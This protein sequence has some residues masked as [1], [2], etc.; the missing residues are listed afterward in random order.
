MGRGP[1][2]NDASAI[3]SYGPLVKVH[4]VDG[5]FELFRAYFAWPSS[6]GA[7][8]REVGAAKG[9]LSMLRRLVA[10]PGVTHVACAFDHVIESFRNQMFAGYKTGEGMDP[11]LYGQ[12]GLAEQVCSALGIVTWSM[13]EFEADDA[14]ATGAARYAA[15]PEVEQVLICSPDKDLMQCVS[16]ERVVCWDR[17]RDRVSGE[18]GVIEKFGIGPA[19][20]PDYLA[21]VG[22]TADGI[23]GIPRWGKKA[24]A[25]LLAE[26]VHLEAIPPAVADW[27]VKPRGAEALAE[28][29]RSGLS[30]ALL[31]REL[32][33]LRLDVPL[34]QATS[35]LRYL[36]AS[37][38][39]LREVCEELADFSPMEQVRWRED[40]PLASHA[41]P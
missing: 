23:P 41:I 19:S 27:R 24:A 36:G 37:R 16:A 6:A 18:A 32:A 21:L 10:E 9:F 30:D 25:T 34:P 11:L 20:I 3:R 13:V 14:L 33:T 5:T 28:T 35:D 26:Y 29:L 8:G 1:Q 31:Y 7:G 38:E 39:R 17:M 22:D 4:L 2:S 15:D 40:A 12:F